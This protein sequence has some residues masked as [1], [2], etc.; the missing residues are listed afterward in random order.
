LRKPSIVTVT[1]LSIGLLVGLA[2][3]ISLFLGLSSAASNTQR[4]LVEQIENYMDLVEERIDS[5]LQPVVAQADWVYDRIARGRISVSDTTQ[6]DDFMSGVVAATPQLAGVAYVNPRGI[7]RRW[8][9]RNTEA[10]VEDWSDRPPVLN[11]LQLGADGAAPEWRE[12]FW[13]DT[14]GEYVLLHD[15]RLEHEGQYLGMFGQVIPINDLSTE[16]DALTAGTVLEPFILYEQGQ[17]LAHRKLLDDKSMPQD[18]TPLTTLNSLDD[19]VLRKIWSEDNR[20]MRFLTKLKRTSATQIEAGER[21]YGL[22]YREIDRYGERPWYIGVHFAFDSEDNTVIDRLV[23]SSFA[24][25]GVLLLSVLVAIALGRKL[26]QPIVSIANVAQTIAEADLAT[27]KTLPGSR[28]REIDAANLAINNM[29]T[30]LRERA[31]IRDTLGRYLPEPVARAVLS[32]GGDLQAESREASVLFCDIEGFTTLSLNIGPVRIVEILNAYFS[33]AV[34]II[35]RNHGVVTQFQGDGIL[36]VFNVPVP[37]D[38][39]AE[40]A[41][42]TATELLNSVDGELFAGEKLS[43]RIGINTGA[44]I[45]GAVGAEGRLSYTVHGD[46]VNK[47]SRIES[48]NK[49]TGTRLL[50]AESTVGKIDREEFIS[51]GCHELRGDRQNLEVFTVAAGQR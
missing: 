34:E 23:K 46:A 39:H 32:S 43:V 40:S 28:V 20:P 21:E 49:E 18:G 11:W 6:L 12:P 48:L 10:I 33:R 4:L 42:K 41:L 3:A 1:C 50:V 7:V 22:L 29:V 36:A 25:I 27:V 44:V 38:K 19:P 8:D 16:L 5:R 47:A 45:A 2:V 30:G 35:E 15:A 31:V 24:G 51:M 13:T 17:V 26:S 37:N 14:I 9:R